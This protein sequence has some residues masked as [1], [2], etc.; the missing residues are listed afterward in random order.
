MGI[1]TDQAM[2][3]EWTHCQYGVTEQAFRTMPEPGLI[4]CLDVMAQA[5]GGHGREAA[6]YRNELTRRETARLN[7]I[8]LGLTVAIFL[9]TG[10]LVAIELDWLR[11]ITGH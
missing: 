6:D 1:I 7:K 5:E 9:L 11:A 4:R 8:L 2:Q 10:V 3:D